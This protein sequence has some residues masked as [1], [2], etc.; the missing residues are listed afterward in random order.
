MKKTTDEKTTTVKMFGVLRKFA[1]AE[2]TLQIM[3]SEKVTVPKLK[4]VLAATLA[5]KFIGF[6]PQLI[7]ASAIAADSEILGAD[8]EV[9]PHAEISVLP[10][11]CGG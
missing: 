6:D 5:E 3:L 11:V 1:D 4:T 7:E 8:A 10:P 2:G 9:V